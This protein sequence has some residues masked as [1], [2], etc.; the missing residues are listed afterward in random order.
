MVDEPLLQRLS[1]D[2]STDLTSSLGDG[3]T[4]GLFDIQSLASAGHVES[5]SDV[6]AL[7]G[8]GFRQAVLA[9]K[10]QHD[11]VLVAGSALGTGAGDAA[12]AAADS[13][14]LLAQAGRTSHDEVA[15][16][17]VRAERLSSPVVGSILCGRAARGR[18]TP[19]ARRDG[20]RAEA[21]VLDH[22]SA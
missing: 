17:A 14:V 10:A 1:V 19:S 11:Y 22:A 2:P 9:L 16:A 6:D 4:G 13:T 12:V 3:P 7:A 18:Q 5:C 8:P 21:S 15:S 20:A